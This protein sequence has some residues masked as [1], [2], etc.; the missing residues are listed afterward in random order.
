[1]SE[2]RPVEGGF[3]AADATFGIVVARWNGEITEGLLE[4]ALRAFKRHGVIKDQLTVVRVPGAFEL[5]LAAQK[6]ARLNKFDAIV[7]LGCVIRGGTPHFEYVCSETTRGIGEVALTE[8]LPVAFGLLT[9]DDLKQAQ[10]RSGD[11]QENKGE[12]AALTVLELVSLYKQ[13]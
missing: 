12:E 8:N 3:H 7:T 6:L 4:G 13:L 2:F 10:D 5:P 11:N 1:M 9:T